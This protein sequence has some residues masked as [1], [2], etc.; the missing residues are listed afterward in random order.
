MV[1]LE[2][3]G[4][5]PTISCILADRILIDIL[6]GIPIFAYNLKM[7]MAGNNSLELFQVNLKR[8]ILF[9]EEHRD[10]IDL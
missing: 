9:E 1:V 6:R 5:Q 2:I 7:G 8:F 3:V 10:G 4:W